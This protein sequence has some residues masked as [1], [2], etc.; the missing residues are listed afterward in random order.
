LAQLQQLTQQFDA[1]VKAYGSG[2]SAIRDRSASVANVTLPSVENVAGEE[3]ILALDT[4]SEL[5]TVTAADAEG[6]AVLSFA[7]QQDGKNGFL[8]RSQSSLST[9]GGEFEQFMRQLGMEFNSG[10]APSGSA[11]LVPGPPVATPAATPVAPLPLMSSVDTESIVQ[12]TIEH[13]SLH[14][15]QDSQVM[16][17]QL[18]PKELGQMRLELVWESDRLKA[19]LQAQTQQVQEVLE[20][21]LPRL[22]DALE[23]QGVNVEEFQVSYDSGDQQQRSDLWD[24]E[25]G[26]WWDPASNLSEELAGALDSEELSA[27]AE[28]M[29]IEQDG[30]LNVHA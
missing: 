30:R 13:L 24:Q 26:P 11:G 16:R 4:D 14:S 1:S 7:R 17:I 20:R 27:V 3:G 25:L 5:L 23:Q 9:S 15:R 28:E 18:Y 29:T 10:Q 2:R 6:D 21:H 8:T 19:H 12:Q 22:R